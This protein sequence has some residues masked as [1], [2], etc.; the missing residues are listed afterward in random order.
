M[1]FYDSLMGAAVLPTDLMNAGVVSATGHVY[2]GRRPQEP[3]LGATEVWVEEMPSPATEGWG[4]Q[5]VRVHEVR[6]HVR[7]EGNPGGDQTGATGLNT[8]EAHMETLRN[9]YDAE[10]LF[11]GT[12][13][14][15]LPARAVVEQVDDDPDDLK[16]TE[17][18][19]RLTFFVK[20]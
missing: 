9:R 7:V 16:V 5:H 1:S 13:A 4:G 15:M 6:L 10:V 2:R 8:V 17:G 11:S 14:G 20:E 18:I 19:L 12:F 3:Q